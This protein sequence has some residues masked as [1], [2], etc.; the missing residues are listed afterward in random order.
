MQC[1]S[2]ISLRHEVA[3]VGAWIEIFKIEEA[4][5]AIDEVAPVGAWIE[6]DLIR[7]TWSHI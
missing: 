5:L 4:K 1:F 6:I 7:L 3:P 2:T